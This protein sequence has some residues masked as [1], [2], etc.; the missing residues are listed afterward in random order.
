MLNRLSVGEW[1]SLFFQGQK[2]PTKGQIMREIDQGNIPG[3]RIGSSK[4][5]YVLCDN[6]YNPV[7][8]EATP[9]AIPETGNTLADG[10]LNKYQI[11]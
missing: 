5:Y 3:G 2:K 9:K 8:E 1:I 6:C 10:I 11:N 4:I 7:D